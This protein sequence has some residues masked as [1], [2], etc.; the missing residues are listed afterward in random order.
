MRRKPKSAT[1]LDQVLKL[2][3]IMA[4]AE[5][6]AYSRDEAAR[7][8]GI[9]RDALKAHVESGHVVTWTDERGE[10]RLPRWQFDAKGGMLTGIRQVL[11][12]FRSGDEW[13]VMRY[14]P[15]KRVSL[16]NKRPLDLLRACEVGR[17]LSHARTQFEENT[18]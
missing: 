17:V 10:P 3:R 4:R 5:G 15:G 14:F 2:T 9:S 8:L 13:R 6:G 11:E 18:W 1:P 7:F 12:V 16:G